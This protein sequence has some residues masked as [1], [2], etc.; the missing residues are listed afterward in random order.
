VE[1]IR[2][3]HD[4]DDHDYNVKAACMDFL[5]SLGLVPNIPDYS[6]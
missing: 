5:G 1:T 6:Q 3:V 2:K 4:M